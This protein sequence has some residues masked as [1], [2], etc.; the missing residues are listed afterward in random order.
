MKHE[1]KSLSNYQTIDLISYIREYIME[2]PNTNIYIGCDSQNA[3]KKTIYALVIVLHHNTRGGHVLY[4]KEVL[5]RIKD[6]FTRIFREVEQS[7][8]IAN[9]LTE[10]NIQPPKYIDIDINP[11]PKYGSNFILNSALGFV[12]SMGYNARCKPNA[13]MASKVADYLI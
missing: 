13:M 11:D 9:Y 3:K 10:Y 4:T 1:F 8:E 7:V 12:E 2:Y 6:R 5:P